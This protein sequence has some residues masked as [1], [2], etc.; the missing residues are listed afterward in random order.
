MGDRANAYIH[1]GE[2]PGV[3]LYT[4]WSGTELPSVV[5]EALAS[6][7]ARRR[8]D[9]G[10]Y[11]ARILFDAMTKGQQGGET[12]FGIWSSAPDGQDRVV[13]IDVQAGTVSTSGGRWTL[14]EYA[15]G[16]ASYEW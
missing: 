8:W 13:S 16:S 9:D 1:D 10:P 2:E 12:G 14:Q 3:Y 15:E 7:N 4:H 6:D 11:L 5:R